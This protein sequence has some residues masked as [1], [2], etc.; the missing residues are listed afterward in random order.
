ME[1]SKRGRDWTNTRHGH[2]TVIKCVG[3][4]HRAHYEWLCVCDCGQTCTKV[5]GMLQRG[6]EY[7]SNRCALRKTNLKHGASYTRAYR[8][9]VSAKSRCYLPTHKNYSTYGGRG[10]SM[11]EGW[12]NDF[13]AFHAYIGEPPT[14]T[15]TLDRIDS[16]GHYEPGNVR[17]A[18]Q[19]EQNRNK[20]NTIWLEIDGER[21]TLID[22]AAAAG[23]SYDAARSRYLSGKRGREVLTPAYKDW[24]GVRQGMLTVLREVGRDTHG[25]RLW[26]CKCECGTEVNKSSNAL[27]NG[28]K[29][30]SA[31][32]GVSA[33]NRAR[34]R[35]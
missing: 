15:H 6:V 25:S 26:A 28:V 3:Q 30:C 23:V 13:S 17:W 16:N 19:H 18:T 27:V 8:A 2:V 4:N 35:L 31:A 10:I 32:C 20:R 1:L 7:C 9:W 12:V 21:V 11:H 29:S 34:T 14:N 5:S 22:A 33:A 24:A